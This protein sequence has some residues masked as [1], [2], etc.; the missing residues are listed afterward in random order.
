MSGYDSTQDT[1]DHMASVRHRLD[2]F[3]DELEERARLHDRSKLQPPEK[4][5]FDAVTPKLKTLTYGSDE[6]KA[7]LAEM[8]EA[9]T[10][11][12]AVNSHHPEHYSLGIS[13]MTLLDL[14][15]M[16]CDWKAAS[17]RHAD[18]DI[19]KSL[20]INVERFGISRQ[21]S[22]ILLN[23]ILDMRWNRT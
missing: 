6:Y 22:V 18:G 16:L 1:L 19:L 17:E 5:V 3:I 12:Y 9:L 2:K 8:G 20:E 21:L 11:H 23:T 7:A 4:A 10:H 14:V 15:E 13:G